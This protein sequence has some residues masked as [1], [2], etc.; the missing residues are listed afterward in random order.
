MI[1][2]PM[3]RKGFGVMACMLSTCSSADSGALM[4]DTIRLRA[5]AGADVGN[6]CASACRTL[7]SL[8]MMCASSPLARP[9]ATIADSAAARVRSAYLAQNPDAQACWSTSPAGGGA[10]QGWPIIDRAHLRRADLADPAGRL[11]AGVARPDVMP[12]ATDP[13]PERRA[14]SASTARS[15]R[16]RPGACSP[17]SST[18]RRRPTR[19]DAV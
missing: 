8:D 19:R 10:R 11:R 12:R 5:G 14:Q 13:S 16:A 17:T 4:T 18:L 6:E 15:S 9:R 2:V 7:G 3:L 1:S